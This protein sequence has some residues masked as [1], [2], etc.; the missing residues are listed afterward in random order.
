MPKARE[1]RSGG[2]DMN[3]NSQLGR[4]SATSS[5]TATF[6]AWVVSIVFAGIAVISFAVDQSVITSAFFIGAETKTETVGIDHSVAVFSPLQLIE[7]LVGGSSETAG[8][9]R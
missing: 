8:H 9:T 3:A 4:Q 6:S 7:S 5:R 1:C 2:T